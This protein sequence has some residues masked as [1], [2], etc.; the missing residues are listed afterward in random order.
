MYGR[1]RLLAFTMLVNLLL[2][3]FVV[4]RALKSVATLVWFVVNITFRN[5]DD[6]PQPFAH[7]ERSGS[8]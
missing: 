3:V 6:L 8:T 1:E 2:S 4:R 5:G 7:D